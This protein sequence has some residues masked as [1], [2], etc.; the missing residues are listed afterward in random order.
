MKGGG[1]P[2]AVEKEGAVNLSP[3][4]SF[5]EQPATLLGYKLREGK[6]IRNQPAKHKRKGV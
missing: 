4:W 2:K 3:S 5:T 1:G 6:W